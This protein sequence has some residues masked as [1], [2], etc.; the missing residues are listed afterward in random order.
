MEFVLLL[1]SPL[2]GAL[3][4]GVVGD[5]RWAPELNAAVSVS[6]RGGRDLVP[7]CR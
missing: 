4:L 5:R 3:V 2:L 7:F 6:R 1:G